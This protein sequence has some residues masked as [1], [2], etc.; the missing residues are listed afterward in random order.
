MYPEIEAFTSLIPLG[1]DMLFES[2]TDGK[3]QGEKKFLEDTKDGLFADSSLFQVLNSLLYREI[4][5]L[6]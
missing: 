1:D 3:T 2:L 4:L 5:K 6:L